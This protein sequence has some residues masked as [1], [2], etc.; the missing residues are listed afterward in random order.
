MRVELNYDA[1][2]GELPPMQMSHLD[3]VTG[4]DENELAELNARIA[5]GDLV[6]VDGGDGGLEG[7]HPR[8]D[9]LTQVESGLGQRRGGQ[10]E[11]PGEIG[12]IGL[13]LIHI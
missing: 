3:P 11:H 12:L 1:Q 13:S 2:Q 6:P 4:M 7:H 5:G 9:L 8:R 10:L